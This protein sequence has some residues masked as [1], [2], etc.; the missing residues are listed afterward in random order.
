MKNIRRLALMVSLCLLTV[1]SL[2]I[3]LFAASACQPAEQSETLDGTYYADVN[4]E[5]YTVA[6][7][8]GDSYAFT[9]SVAGDDRTG[10]YF[11]SGSAVTLT[12]SEEGET[13]SATLS[14]DV[15]SF[16]YKGTAYEMIPMVT[17]TVTFDLDGGTGTAS[18]QVV[19][20]RLLPKPAD[21]QK[22][23]NVFIGWYADSAFTEKFDFETQKITGNVT[24]YARFVEGP[25]AEEFTVS[26]ETGSGYEGD[27]IADVQTIGHGIY[28]LPELPAL[29]GK[30]FLG[31][32]RSDYE[33]AAKL[34]AMVTDGYEVDE[35][36]TLFAVW[37]SDAPAVSVTESGVSWLSLG[38]NID[39][40]VTI[41]GPDDVT[42]VDGEIVTSLSRSFAFASSPAGDYEIT[43][44]ANHETTT[45]YYLNKGLARVTF[46]KVEGNVLLFT[47]VE[48][49]EYY[50]ISYTCGTAE[51]DH[52]TEPVR[53][54]TPAYDFSA[55]D[56]VEGGISFVVQSCAEGYVTSTSEPFV[57]E[58]HLDEVTG[59]AVNPA[60][61]VL[62]W[63]AV[64][65][66]Q[67]Y[68]VEVT[69][70][71]ET[72]VF[73]NVT[74][75]SLD[76]QQFY[77]ELT[78]EI[79]PEA[80]GYNSSAVSSTYNKV[81][82]ATPENIRTSLD[83]IVW[84]A[85]DGAQAYIVTIDGNEHRVTEPSYSPTE[86]DLE[87]L[88]NEFSVSVVALAADE[89]NNSFAAQN[90]VS[91][92]LT[93]IRYE[94]GSVSWSAV[95]GVSEYGVRVNDG[96][97]FIVSDATSTPVTLT[98][99]GTNTI[100]VRYYMGEEESGWV[101]ITVDANVTVT[102]N[103]NSGAAS[104]ETPLYYASGDSILLPADS[105][106]IGYTFSGWYTEQTGGQKVE[107]GTV[108]ASANVTY[109]AHWTANVYTITLTVPETEGYF[110]QDDSTKLQS[111]KVE[112]TFGQGFTFNTPLSSDGTMAFGGW[113]AAQGGSG[114]QYTDP[115]GSSLEGMTWNIASDATL[116]PGWLEAYSYTRIVHPDD[117]SRSA[118]SVSQGPGIIYL[119]EA[120][121]PA[122]YEGLPVTTIEGSC[123]RNCSN[124]KVINIP[125]SILTVT[126][127]TDGPS[128][129]GS[130]FQGCSSLEEVNVYAVP[131]ITGPKPYSSEGGALIYDNEYTGVE[132]AYVPTAKT[133]EY[134][135]PSV[136]EIIPQLAFRGT[137]VSIINVPA[138]VT[139]IGYRAFYST[140]IEQV[141]FLEPEEGIE[142]VGLTIEEEAFYLSSIE[143][144]TLPAH[145]VDFDVSIFSGCNDLT[146]VDLISDENSVYTSVDGVIFTDSGR[147]LYYFPVA[148]D[149]VYTVPSG[150]TRI[151]DRAFYRATRL[152]GIIIPG[153]VEEIGAEAFYGATRLQNID[154]QGG[155]N[156]PALSIEEYAFYGCT[157]LNKL[158]LP[159]NLKVL[160]DYAFGGISRLS[161]VTINTAIK[162]I[163]YSN[164]A[165]T[166]TSGTVS[167]TTVEL[168]PEVPEF[169]IAG[170]F[171]SA[172]LRDVIVDENNPNFESIDGVLFN[173]DG[174][175]ILY[176]PNGRTGAYT[177][178]DTV[179]GIGG[180]VF[181][182]NTNLTGITI[183]HNVTSIGEGAFNGCTQLGF[184]SF[185]G[186]GTKL[187]IGKRAFLSCTSLTELTIPSWT[188]SIGDEAFAGCT[189]LTSV[190]VPEG[191]TSIGHAAFFYA[192]QLASISLPSTLTS[193]GVYSTSYVYSDIGILTDKP[194]DLAEAGVNN[195]DVFDSCYALATITIPEG[196][197]AYTV[198]DGV[199]Y[200]KEE[201]VVTTLYF[202][203]RQNAGDDS[204][205]VNIPG[206]VKTI[207]DR[208]FYGNAQIV[209][210]NFEDRSAATKLEVGGAVFQNCSSLSSVELPSGL[211]EIPKLMFE[212]ASIQE[213]NIP[214][215]VSEIGAGAFYNCEQLEVVY[216]EP[217]NLENPLTL[218]DHETKS[219][220]SNQYSYTYYY[221]V[222]AGCTS[223]IHIEFPE[224]TVQIGSNAFG[225]DYYV[226]YSGYSGKSNL[227][228]VVLPSTLTTIGD[229]AFYEADQLTSVDFGGAGTTD[230]SIGANAFYGSG[231]TSVVLPDRPVSV[232]DYAF[233][234]ADSL[235]TVTIS[236]SVTSIGSNAFSN[237]NVLSSVLIKEDNQLT[238]IGASAFS[239]CPALT[240]ITLENSTV[241]ETIG[242]SAFANTG[243]TSVKIPAS[244]KTIGNS[245]FSNCMSLSE[246][247]LLE[248]GEAGQ[249]VSALESVGNNAF[250]NTA[251][252]EFRFPE[253]SNGSITLGN[254]LFQA[255]PNLTTVHL[256]TSIFDLGQALGKCLSLETITVAPGGH[257]TSHESQPLL[258]NTADGAQEIV[259]AFGPV[260]DEENG[261]AYTLPDGFVSIG[262]GA[263]RGQNGIRSL[264]L[265]S[266]LTT[267]GANAFE[268]CRGLETIVF[269]EQ[270]LLTSIGA[271][272]FDKCI[273]LQ[274]VNLPEGL[275]TLGSYAF[276][277]NSSLESVDMPSTLKYIG[278][279]AFRDN[280]QL[281]T[282]TNIPGF[283]PDTYNTVNYTGRY[284][285][286]G[287]TSLS[288]V[289]FRSDFTT[290]T[291][292]MFQ[293]TT[294]LTSVEFPAGITALTTYSPSTTSSFKP[295]NKSGLTEVILNDVAELPEGIFSGAASL[296]TADLSKVTEVGE[297]AFSGCDLLEV[298][299]PVVTTIGDDAFKDNASLTKVTLNDTLRQIGESAFS[300]CTSLA[301]ADVY[302][303]G[304]GAAG[305]EEGV[306]QLPSG[307]TTIGKNA[308]EA[309]A[310]RKVVI[311]EGVTQL[312]NATSSVTAS[313]FSSSAFQ[314]CTSLTEV[315]LPYTLTDIG[316][317]AFSGCTS[318]KTV[319]YTNEGGELVGEEG[320]V[321]LP[322]V[323][324]LGAR[325]FEGT[326]VESAV[327]PASVTLL[328]QY[329]FADCTA[330]T[331]AEY[332]TSAVYYSSTSTTATYESTNL[333]SGCT[334]LEEVIL[335]DELDILPGSLFRGCSSLDTVGVRNSDTG[336]VDME[337]G[338]VKLPADLNYFGTF[339]FAGSG[340]TEIVIPR[341]ITKLSSAATNYTSD[342]NLFEGCAK[343]EKV[344]LHDMITLIGEKTFND[345]SALKTI[346]Y[347]DAEGTIHGKEGK[348]TLPDS[349]EIIGEYAFAN[350]CGIESITIPA[351]VQKIGRYVFEGN[352]NLRSVEYLTTSIVYNTATNY[353][354]EMFQ[355][356]TSLTSV[357]LNAD[358]KRIPNYFFDGCTSLTTIKLYDADA[359]GGAAVIGEDGKATLPT[360]LQALGIYAFR[361]CSSL[362]DLT[363][364]SL[365]TNTTY[366]SSSMPFNG[367]TSLASVTLGEGVTIGV[368]NNM[369][370][371]CSALTSVTLAE[372]I[373]TIG[374]YAFYG[375][376]ITSV[377]LPSTV[378]SIGT[379]SFSNCSALADITFPASL[380]TIGNYAFS[381]CS[382][383]T[384]VDLSGTALT[385]IGSG[386]FNGCSALAELELN[387]GL[388][389]IGADAF[390][391]TAIEA[392]QLPS[393]VTSIGDNAFCQ[394]AVTVADGSAGFISQDGVL[395][396]SDGVVIATP[397]T[398]SGEYVVPEEVAQIGSYALNG[399]SLTKVTLSTDQL[400]DYSFA[401]F[402]GEVVVTLGESTT[403][404]ANAFSRY[405]GSSI[406]LPEGLTSIGANAFSSCTGP[407][408]LVLPSTVTSIG[409]N[410]F[411][412]SSFTTIE[413]PAALTSIG[414]SAFASSGLTGIVIPAGVEEIAE[415]AFEGSASLA[416]VE[417]PASLTVLGNYAFADCTALTS[418][419]LP[420]G[421]TKIG[422][423][424]FDASGLTSLVIPSTV[425]SIGTNA[426]RDTALTSFEIRAG[427]LTSLPGSLLSSKDIVT[428][429]VPYGVTSLGSSFFAK[430]ALLETVYLPDT[431]TALPA[432]VFSGCTALKN[433]YT[434]SLGEDGG[435]I[436]RNNAEMAAGVVDISAITTIEQSAFLEAAS[437]QTVIFSDE[438]TTIGKSAFESSGL[439][440][441]TIPGTVSLTSTTQ[442]YIFRYCT[443][444][445]TVVIE[446]GFTVLPDGM[447]TGCTAL[448]SVTLP[449]TVT[450]IYNAFGDCTSIS[451]IVI[452]ASVTN[453]Y[454]MS[455]VGWTAD[456]T[457][458]FEVYALDSEYAT[459]RNWDT[460]CNAKFEVSVLY[461]Y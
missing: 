183:G 374:N 14:G 388:K 194:S 266:T 108:T 177:L 394:I 444:L 175:R 160:E 310:I 6:F 252:A 249:E 298:Y 245:A 114:L 297:S 412:S 332:L 409:N 367:C 360:A 280:L 343:L 85:V 273:S 459:I 370:R 301:T 349:L 169:D 52:V 340:I 43:V 53:V 62:S 398:M 265:P 195:I 213:I 86:A 291:E 60:T 74:D 73:S 292:Y 302:K 320:A 33:D 289:T 352:T 1:L 362:T 196:N 448:T 42:Y 389:T 184:V 322:D 379:Y 57:F 356:C 182:G 410:A 326:A 364:P 408:T 24:L 383:L 311:P 371:D 147:T 406:T 122:T 38:V 373:D 12:F 422:N 449:D 258:L 417:L 155:R 130:A 178:P 306:A 328:G 203:P 358:I 333:F 210:V 284:M 227:E 391:N 254:Y 205:T 8:S 269:S 425:T 447:F 461:T 106:R 226:G 82:L 134:T 40:T 452:P 161:S 124:L 460:N 382:A 181:S 109:Y 251:I 236:V 309:T 255:C 115:T 222:F 416:S 163:D 253:S 223:L 71:G 450:T 37:E 235:T 325:A 35:N 220:G 174:T 95:M 32:W 94:N 335:T 453:I 217:G 234:N 187:E 208:A 397:P 61:D 299:L 46:F 76:L 197:A 145:L 133:G 287:C 39:Y 347:T 318:L 413:L 420:E 11:Y 402:T 162:E 201:G 107:S 151:N 434:Y 241:L 204:N 242:T 211:T 348:A 324:L 377:A 246:I 180:G 316:A 148:R 159:A 179:T 411:E 93:N 259:M 129:T 68:T 442:R 202:S 78:I 357:V 156:D 346:Q 342:A 248:A 3:V 200:G 15:L 403:I 80:F 446:E 221:G 239:S 319:R 334:S 18:A 317:N 28:N 396:T 31:W 166:S 116:Y 228:S 25:A 50:L 451:S 209:T 140:R 401:Y 215:T 26:F 22:D 104:I 381:G 303:L 152:E 300:G 2:G 431:L 315:V 13:L 7:S 283:T 189:G 100:S 366:G 91:R 428:F 256:S 72:E 144:I 323:T 456:Q 230:L 295:F 185:T 279:Y 372:G 361:N 193:M 268:Y 233:Y 354:A 173:S 365:K 247:T 426:L 23:G 336:E 285:F 188:V 307:L 103:N 433:V 117:P 55:C 277:G 49:A 443:S 119:K 9:F 395:L 312:G 123:F 170:V 296:Q 407:E 430:A 329:V 369:F 59:I 424:A 270:G 263:F 67:S 29:D 330:L 70:G 153:H 5:E 232:G 385:E 88:G 41:T 440:S 154:F 47:P 405:R 419:E 439:V 138:T 260:A 132:L 54:V 84:D 441:V 359:E 164:Q 262:P 56:M 157:A 376:G 458:I 141:N 432:S 338:V 237:C 102:L 10:T 350:D 135:V 399:S 421:L 21:P 436:L 387:E 214:N 275:Y 45:V 113:Y 225:P 427:Q 79:T 400:A 127:S 380:E 19:N 186:T 171:G 327:I 172:N 81:R 198:I 191:V 288:K 165:F 139:R 69:A 272:A 64:A 414:E 229:R 392:M 121:V 276:A 176:Y 429:T 111:I 105:S 51:H 4:G 351:S 339:V 98:Q 136:V 20:G 120:T 257:F 337:E 30:D 110:E 355:N 90:T 99:S 243:L 89:A 48:N 345:C 17:Y 331:H 65:N 66:A 142:P 386:A 212:G 126:L 305:V 375:T 34:T 58:R 96:Q 27:P 16:T 261:G 282:V 264:T 238:S 321:T 97:E 77:G 224:R 293:E 435:M 131:E 158:E 63:D 278:D 423:Y 146:T 390:L 304:Q 455:F 313:S 368:P 286:D 75:T 363:I 244:I 393:T 218:A 125:D 314:D 437:I 83:S 384:A 454:S 216:F 92:V 167:I 137:Y 378:E 290:L 344:V 267:I 101:D 418:I 341:A 271:N 240:S 206:T 415:S 438:L 445:K 219:G 207:R 168:G 457:I 36:T 199:I 281:T 143:A 192:T 231:I 294:S 149:G 150:V 250:Q 128:G 274:S 87:E 44:S 404:P 308:F 353:A 112:V 190:T 118:Y